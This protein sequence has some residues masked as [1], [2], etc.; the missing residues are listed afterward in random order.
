MNKSPYDW[1]QVQRY[2]DR[3]KSGRKTFRHFGM[4]SK[5]WHDARRKGWIVVQDIRKPIEELLSRNTS[6]GRTHVKS[7]LIKAGLL[8]Y[9][10]YICGLRNWRGKRLSLTLDH[11]NGNNGDWALENLRLLCPNCNS[12][13]ETFSG[14]NIKRKR[15]NTE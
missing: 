10:C 14:R 8:S 9:R 3:V 2:Y 12:Q 7:R 1:K 13:T 11:I 6:S 5:T 4:S 15:L